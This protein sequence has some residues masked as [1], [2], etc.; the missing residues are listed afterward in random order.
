MFSNHVAA[1]GRADMEEEIG[2][3]KTPSRP[4]KLQKN[5]KKVDEKAVQN[6]YNV[7]K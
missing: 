7:F 5:R 2:L 6:Y 4:K 1:K 3:R